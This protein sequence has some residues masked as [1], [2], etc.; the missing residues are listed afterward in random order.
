MLRLEP[1]VK[2]AHVLVVDDDAAIRKA[3]KFG[4][5]T[6]GLVVKTFSGGRQML[7]SG[8]VNQADCLVLD[9]RMAGMDG[10]AVVA[11]LAARKARIP[12][13][14][15]TAPVTETMR[16]RAHEAGVFSLLEKPLLD[17]V[18]ADNIRRAT[19]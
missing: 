11:E 3:L 18:L 13:I 9:C 4:L 1:T 15:M 6:E 5:E 16:R 19:A 10:F 2:N 8:S 12:V 7:E 17:G 14:L